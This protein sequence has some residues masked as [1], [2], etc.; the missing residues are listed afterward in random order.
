MKKILFVCTGN[1]CR[2]PMAAAI[3][4]HFF[5]NHG[6]DAVAASCGV[7]AQDGAEASAHAAAV[8]VARG[9]CVDGHR[10]KKISPEDLAEADLIIAMTKGHKAHLLALM[11]DFVEKIQTFGELCEIKTVDISDPFGGS[12]AVYQACAAQISE[13]IENL[14]WERFL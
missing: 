10:A 13:Y 9:L 14:D 4:N 11:S 6:L 3:A 5:K 2:S 1:T 7:F 12:E 8:M